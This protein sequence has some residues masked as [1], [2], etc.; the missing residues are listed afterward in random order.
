MACK[1]LHEHLESRDGFAIQVDQLAP[2]DLLRSEA[3]LTD[4]L[5]GVGIGRGPTEAEARGRGQGLELK[6][7]D[8]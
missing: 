4:G 1:T 6:E 3:D 2:D 8:P 5:L 7:A